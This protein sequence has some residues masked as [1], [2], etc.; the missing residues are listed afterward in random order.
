MITPA[1]RLII[2]AG[3]DLMTVWGSRE[4]REAA[5]ALLSEL[6]TKLPCAECLGANEDPTG[7]C[8]CDP[9]EECEGPCRTRAHK[10]SD[11]E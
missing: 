5:A 7:W 1:D 2:A 4:E 3:L 10:P 11:H 6:D 9:D 8:R